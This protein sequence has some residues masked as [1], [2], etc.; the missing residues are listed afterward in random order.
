VFEDRP[1]CG[2]GEG[3]EQVVAGGLHG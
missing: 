2:V 3:F 1:A